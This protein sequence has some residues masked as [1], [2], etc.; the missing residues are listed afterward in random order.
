MAEADSENIEDLVPSAPPPPPSRL[1]TV[2]GWVFKIAF[3]GV[4]F[5]FL[6]GSGKLKVE[7]I[8]QLGKRWDLALLAMFM[9]IP[10]LAVCSLRYQ[11]LLKALNI[12]ARYT[13][14]F[15]LTM[16][17]MLFDLI[18]PVSN[19]GDLVKG[20][21]LSKSTRSPTGKTNLGIILFSVLLDRIVGLFALFT[22][23]L[24]VCVAAWSQIRG[25]PE[26][27]KTAEIV[28][29][30]CIVGL[31]G[32]FVMVSETL[33]KS[34]LRKRLMH[35]I[36]FHEKIEQIY[37][38]FASLRHHKFTLLQM[39]AL[40]I[41]N[42]IFTCTAILILAQ[43]MTFTSTVTGQPA[44]LELMPCL[45]VLPLGLFATTFGP[46]GGLGGGNAAFEYL[47]HIVLNLNGGAALIL[48]FQI[49]GIL[50]RLTGVPVMILYRNKGA[51]LELTPN[52]KQP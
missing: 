41:M 10:A 5:A 21:Y 14:I 2:L 49:C 44:P 3:L 27:R 24:I 31:L 35:I 26:L 32:F 38:G 15:A 8:L 40:S 25:S 12:T 19:G 9:A 4:I 30:V 43:G 39:L 47:F 11:L 36:P 16:I 17:G 37:S 52:V 34:A 28:V 29:L 7:D 22:F 23:A 13:D 46:A 20:I 50:F 48:K 45:T 51:N 6:F 33:E 42:H 18:S 1:R